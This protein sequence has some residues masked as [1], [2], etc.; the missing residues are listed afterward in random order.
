[1]IW[2]SNSIKFIFYKGFKKK[3]GGHP[4]CY[5]I[6]TKDTDVSAGGNNNLG[7][8]QKLSGLTRNV[9]IDN[10]GEPLN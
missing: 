5:F 7:L 6:D 1:M 10:P 8:L 4:T 3:E 2:W 9:K